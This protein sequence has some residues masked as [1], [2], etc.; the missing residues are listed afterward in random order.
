MQKSFNILHS[1][2][3]S[4]TGDDSS[5]QLTIFKEWINQTNSLVCASKGGRWK[6]LEKTATETSSASGATY[7]LA[8]NIRKLISVKTTVGTIDYL[9]FGIDSPALW[10]GID[11]LNLG[12]SDVT[13]FWHQRGND[14]LVAP[15]FSSASN[16]ITYTYRKKVKE[17]QNDDFTTGSVVSATNGSKTITGTGTSWTA[18]MNGRW[19][20]IRGTNGDNQWYQIATRDSATSLTL[21]REYQG[22]TFSAATD[23]YTISEMPD[24]PGEYHDLCLWRPLALFYMMNEQP[25][26]AA[27]YWKMYDGGKE[28][29]L[30]DEIGGLLGVMYEE[31]PDGEEGAIINSMPDILGRIRNFDVNTPPSSTITFSDL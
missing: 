3:Q 1:Q 22:T 24:M 6:F 2:L 21:E 28:A 8:A 14:L 19:I 27:Q 31:E 11:A 7:D 23:A 12:D 18:L 5:A 9:P 13:L 26:L 30:S 25:T 20:R 17:M 16:T 10:D 4:I 15:A 29:G